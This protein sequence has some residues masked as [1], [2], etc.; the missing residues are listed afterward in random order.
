MGRGVV[1]LSE[2]V[3]QLEPDRSFS[4]S[5]LGGVSAEAPPRSERTNAA[6]L[7]GTYL[8]N[9]AQ[10]FSSIHENRIDDLRSNQPATFEP[11]REMPSA[12]VTVPNAAHDTTENSVVQEL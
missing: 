10:S 6:T 12:E 3:L 8:R 1:L 4:E 2:G 7:G 9:R 5:M 11:S